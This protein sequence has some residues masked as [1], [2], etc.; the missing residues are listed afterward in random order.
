VIY[1]GT[2]G[3][4]FPDWIGHVYPRDIRKSQMLRYYA[5]IWKFNALEL[6]FTY[7]RLPSTKTIV[8]LLRSTPSDMI[9][10]IKLPASVTHQGWKKER[11]PEE[12]LMSFLRAVEPMISERRLKA[13]LAQFPFSFRYNERNLDYIASIADKANFKLA[14]ELRNKSWDRESFYSWLRERGVSLVTVDEPRLPGLF[15]YRPILTSETAYF[16][17]HGRNPD[18]FKASAG[19]RYKYD[20]SVAEL[21]SFVRDVKNVLKSASDVFVF[22]NNCYRGNAVRNALQFKGFFDEAN[23]VSIDRTK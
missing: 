7:Y 11:V 9:F 23:S 15:P 21:A 5:F 12:D 8:S 14:V 3:F 22:F 18:W 19:E 13:I 2:S 10:T 17:F 6:N 1:I 16:R 20:Y 4:S